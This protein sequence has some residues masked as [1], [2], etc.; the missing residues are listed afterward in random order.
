MF[1]LSISTVCVCLCELV[2]DLKQY[3]TIKFD[4]QAKKTLLDFRFVVAFLVIRARPLSCQW[5][6]LLG[7]VLLL[8]FSLFFALSPWFVLSSRLLLTAQIFQFCF[9]ANVT[10]LNYIYSMKIIAFA[11]L[12]FK[13]CQVCVCARARVCLCVCVN[14]HL[15]TSNHG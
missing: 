15:N 13:F 9:N 2:H 12:L 11:W 1:I 3:S 6:S 7:Y 14:Q 5:C 10:H 8:L 4:R